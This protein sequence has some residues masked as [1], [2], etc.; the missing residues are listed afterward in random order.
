MESSLS[1]H[2][3]AALY[4]YPGPD[5]LAQFA[6]AQVL[7]LEVQQIVWGHGGVLL[8]QLLAEVAGTNAN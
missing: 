6:I 8:Y 5:A 7:R 1:C 2:I 4:A 3:V